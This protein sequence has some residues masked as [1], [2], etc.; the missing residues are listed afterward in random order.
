[1]RLVCYVAIALAHR[2]LFLA[3]V[4]NTLGVKVSKTGRRKTNKPAATVI[5][6]RKKM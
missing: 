3:N 4:G 6:A 1:M 5:E 2:L